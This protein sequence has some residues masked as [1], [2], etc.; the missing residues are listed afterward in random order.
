M[1]ATTHSRFSI[2]LHKFLSIFSP[3]HLWNLVTSFHL[4]F[5]YN[6][7]SPRLL[8][9]CNSLWISAPMESILYPGISHVWPVVSHTSVSTRT[10]WRACQN[11]LPWPLQSFWFGRS[12]CGPR[13]GFLRSQKMMMRLVWDLILKT[14]ALHTSLSKILIS[15]ATNSV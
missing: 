5:P 15:W 2:I 9:Y 13:P 3:T 11:T 6:F 10:T 12:S 8:V 1:G 14:T 4:Q 7:K